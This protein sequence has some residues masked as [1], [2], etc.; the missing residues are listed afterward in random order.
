MTGM[1]TATATAPTTRRLMTEAEVEELIGFAKGTLAKNRCLRRAHPPYLKLGSA[2]RYRPAAVE[3]W[4]AAREVQP[5]NQGMP[6]R[7]RR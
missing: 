3:K 5:A 1:D 7:S 4:L 2:I 6:R